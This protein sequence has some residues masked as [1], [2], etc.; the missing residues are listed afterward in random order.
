MAQPQ[1]RVFRDYMLD[2]EDSWN[3]PPRRP[4]SLNQSSDRADTPQTVVLDQPSPVKERSSNSIE[5]RSN[6]RIEERSNSRVEERS[7]SRIEERPGGRIEY[8]IAQTTEDDINKEHVVLHPGYGPGYGLARTA[9]ESSYIDDSSSSHSGGEPIEPT[10]EAAQVETPKVNGLANGMTIAMPPDVPKKR[11]T[12]QTMSPISERNTIHSIHSNTP[13]SQAPSKFDE[14]MEHKMPEFFSMTVF[15]AALY[16]PTISHQLLKFGQSRLCGE[17]M[18]FLARVHK[19]QALVNEVSRAVVEMH[20]EFISP[21]APAQI[22][23]PE[24]VRLRTTQ[25]AKVSL[26]STVPQLENLFVHAQTDIEN[27]VYSDV[28]PKFVRHQMTLSAAKALG[29]DRKQ[30]A[31]LGDCFVLTDPSKVCEECPGSSREANG[32]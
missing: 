23:V 12:R 14:R 7:N 21:T 2:D 22:N 18:E 3:V 31:G 5:R 17:N 30:Y 11:S 32:C 27:L 20:D 28:Y 6:S 29:G 15:Q 13:S 9:D 1:A 25:D 16:N 26:N 4:P 10:L 24:P 19:Y 8:G